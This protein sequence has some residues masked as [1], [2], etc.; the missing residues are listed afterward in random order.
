MRRT[1]SRPLTIVMTICLALTLTACSPT[2]GTV[3][4]KE[5]DDADS[6]RETCSRTV[7]GKATGYPCTKRDGEHWRLQL[8]DG[9]ESG[10]RDVARATYEACRVGDYYDENGCRAA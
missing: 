10:W 2:A 8:D 1:T 5:Y 6:W 7:N 3:L 4:S 9:D